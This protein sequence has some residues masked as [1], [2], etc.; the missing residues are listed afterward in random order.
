[1]TDGQTDGQTDRILLA[2]TRLHYVQRG[3]NWPGV[4]TA[5]VGVYRDRGGEGAVSTRQQQY[6]QMDDVHA[7]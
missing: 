4:P 2:I 6:R 7:A 1:M 5:V 3:K